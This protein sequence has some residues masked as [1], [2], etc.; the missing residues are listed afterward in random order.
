MLCKAPYM[1][2]KVGITR[3]MTILSDEAR[4]AATP[5]PC[6]QC[7]PCRINKARVWT[8]RI[9]LENRTSSDSCFITLTYDEENCPDGGDLI[10]SHLTNF[11]KRLRRRLEPKK[12]RY[13][14]VGEYGEKS[15]RPHFHLIIFGIGREFKWHIEDIWKEGMT[16][17]GEV[18]KDSSRYITGYVIKNWTRK[19]NEEL[20]GRSPEFTRMSKMKGGIGYEAI[21]KIGEKLRE[22]EYFRKRIVRELKY[23][24]NH[25][26]PLGRYLI[27]KLNDIQGIDRNEIENDFYEYQEEIF[28][29]HMKEI[30]F[31]DSVVK[32]KEGKRKSVVKKHKIWNKK[33]GI[34]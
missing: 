13:F 31:Y 1:R 27:G 34:I 26:M 12:I 5:F 14:G 8:H 29:K 3:E 10:S 20:K 9:M 21:E 11:I 6:G 17:V 33:R 25:N 23:G 4:M 22:N 28:D 24:K 30:C 16:H 15:G 7:L 18:N 19:D 2:K 32:E